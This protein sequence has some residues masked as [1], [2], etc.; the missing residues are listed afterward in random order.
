MPT[1]SG[2]DEAKKNPPREILMASVKC[3]LLSEARLMARKRKEVRMLWR[4]AWRGFGLINFSS[5]PRRKTKPPVRE[6]VYEPN[7]RARLVKK[8]KTNQNFFKNFR[9]KGG[10]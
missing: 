6:G 9:R 2:A 7:K 8:K 3:S 5:T 1:C 4:G 10:T